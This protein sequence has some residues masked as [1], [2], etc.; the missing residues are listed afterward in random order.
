MP[1]VDIEIDKRISLKAK[2]LYYVLAKTKATGVALH[3]MS[4]DGRDSHLNALKELIKYG[5]VERKAT[6]N[7]AGLFSYEYTVTEN[8][9]TDKPE[10]ENPDLTIVNTKQEV[11]T[12][13]KKKVSVSKFSTPSVEEVCDYMKSRLWKMPE[14][15]SA[16][17]VDFYSAKG[18][19]VGKNKMKD[20]KASVRTWERQGDNILHVNTNTETTPAL[21]KLYS[22]DWKTAEDIIVVKAAVY[23]VENNVNPPADLSKRFYNNQKLETVF[24]DACLSKGLEAK[25]P[26]S[27]TP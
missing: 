14:E 15:Q 18:W 2:G 17:F 4:K 9:Y 16:K 10:S 12:T 1:K 6:R 22:I 25:L 26:K 24:M 19:M 13:V 8:P 7:V 20:W 23:C 5:Y 27:I 21:K 3:A 11:V